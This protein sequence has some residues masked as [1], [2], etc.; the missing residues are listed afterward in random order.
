VEVEE[1][2]EEGVLI[3]IAEVALVVEEALTP[4]VDMV[5]MIETVVVVMIE[6]MIVAIMIE[7]A[8]LTIIMIGL[9]IA[10]VEELETVVIQIEWVVVQAIILDPHR[11]NKNDTIFYFHIIC[12]SFSIICRRL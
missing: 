1:E 2:V 8:I 7:E 3:L 9:K 5:V 4:A 11:I 10:I 6:I 12:I